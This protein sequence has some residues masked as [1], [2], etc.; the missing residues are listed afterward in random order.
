MAT[1]EAALGD[2]V[3]RTARGRRRAHREVLEPYGLSPHQA[4]AM[5]VIAR[6]GD[7]LR[8]S[9][10]AG[11][12]SIAPRLATDVVDALG[13]QGLVHRS[14]SEHDRRVV[15]LRP[16]NNGLAMCR[17]LDRA[18]STVNREHFG[19]LSQQ[20]RDD[21]AMSSQTALEPLASQ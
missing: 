18:R 13:A 14:P 19:A 12:L 7:G 11:E 4:R 21:L 5:G 20:Q 17:A 3:E 8:L 2:L 15:D 6:L 16:I 1:N 9:T 10:L